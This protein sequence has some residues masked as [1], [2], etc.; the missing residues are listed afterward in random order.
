MRGGA[1]LAKLA[2]QDGHGTAIS[3]LLWKVA[4]GGRPLGS[5][6][7]LAT[8]SCMFSMFVV[9]MS[10]SSWIRWPS[11]WCSPW[12]LSCCGDPAGGRGGGVPEV[13]SCCCGGGGGG[14]SSGG[15]GLAV[16]VA[17]C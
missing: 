7:W 6:G 2:P 10:I 14:G 5:A 13:N 11:E 16:V 1:L 8:W 17:P 9:W 15:G 3:R 12:S 4:R